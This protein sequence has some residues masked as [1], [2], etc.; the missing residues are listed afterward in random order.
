MILP[1]AGSYLIY[2][3]KETP[4]LA[5]ISV[6]ELMFTAAEIG[7][8]RFQYLEPVTVCGALF[9]VMSIGASQVMRLIERWYG[10]RWTRQ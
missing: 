9:L 8:D 2:M 5:A 3:F 10:R 4:L 7:S 1:A 6:P